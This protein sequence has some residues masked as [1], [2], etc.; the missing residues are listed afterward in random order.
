MAPPSQEYYDKLPVP[1]HA[2]THMTNSELYSEVTGCTVT[3]RG[4]WALPGCLTVDQHLF[5]TSLFAWSCRCVTSTSHPTMQ[6]LVSTTS[7][8]KSRPLMY[9]AK[10]S[11]PPADLQCQTLK[12]IYQPLPSSF[13]I[14]LQRVAAV[15]AVCSSALR[16]RMISCIKRAEVAAMTPAGG[17]G[18][19][20]EIAVAPKLP[21][22]TTGSHHRLSSH[23]SIFT[24]SAAYSTESTTNHIVIT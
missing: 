4:A 9:I 18:V 3:R 20:V 23:P 5:T 17:G 21:P 13:W 14:R 7:R 10:A 22:P 8:S 1:S 15:S 6:H 11:T 19:G 2:H 16:V 24:T 12:R